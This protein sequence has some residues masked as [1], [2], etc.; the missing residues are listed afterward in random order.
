MGHAESAFESMADH[1]VLSHL[2]HAKQV[3]PFKTM[4]VSDSTASAKYFGALAF[5]CNVFLRAHID[6]D[7]T[8]SIVQVHLKGR[9][10]YNVNDDI[11]VYFC[12]P[13]LGC[14]VPLRPGD[15]LI[16]NAL[17]PHCISSRCRQE[18]K[19]M[20]IS[21]YLKTSVVGMNDNL[22]PVSSDQLSL[23]E[24]FCKINNN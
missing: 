21:S 17:V 19:L 6:D 24:R 1:Q 4:S 20:I 3:V 18:D 23:A 15:F 16:F 10:K 22:L 5:G 14:V 2:Y 9:N 13:T 7:F 11:V 8:M 12:F